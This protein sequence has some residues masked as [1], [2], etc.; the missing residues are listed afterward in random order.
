MDAV[1]PL[2]HV[3][4]T[5]P[6]VIDQLQKNFK[7]RKIFVLTSIANCPTLR[8]LVRLPNLQCVDQNTV[9]PNL[10]IS[11]I[12]SILESIKNDATDHQY[13]FGGHSIAGWYLQQFLKLG[14]GFSNLNVTSRYLVWDSD[15]VMLQNFYAPHLYPASRSGVSRAPIVPI[16]TFQRC[17]LEYVETYSTLTRTQKQYLKHGFVTH[18]MVMDTKIVADMMRH[19]CMNKNWHHCWIRKILTAS[20]R[21]KTTRF[22]SLGFS[23]YE[24]FGRWST[25][26]HYDRVKI[27]GH[28]NHIVRI[29]SQ[30]Q[31]CPE[32]GFLKKKYKLE[33][34]VVYEGG[35]C[36]RNNESI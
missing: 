25:S 23:E 33:P 36:K 17:G 35:A 27:V 16:F 8:M 24:T 32:I 22:C 15:A 18:N 20:C 2:R 19:V 26:H 21:N 6:M 3:R 31:C 7:P 12:K 9:F 34:F 14:I 4:C 1:I 28:F 5:T 30:R 29:H 11:S 13:G 10:S